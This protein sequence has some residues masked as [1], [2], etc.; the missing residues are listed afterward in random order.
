MAEHDGKV[1]FDLEIDDSRLRGDLSRIIGQVKG[2]GNAKVKVEADTGTAVSSLQRVKSQADNI[3]STKPIV[4]VD[5]QTGTANTALDRTKT[6]ADDLEATDPTVTV[7]AQTGGAN[8]TLDRTKAKADDLESSDPT[9]TVTAQTGE[10]NGALEHTL[11]LA[12]D[13]EA[14]DPTVTI[15]A[16]TSEVDKALGKTG[17]GESGGGLGSVVSGAAAVGAA[18]NVFSAG[19]NYD[20]GLAQ[21]ATLMPENADREAFGRSMLA[22]ST[23]YGV[24]IETLLETAY[25]GL[26]ASV[27]YGNNAAGNNLAQFVE[28]ATKLS[29]AGYTTP[30]NAGDALSSVYNAYNGTI[31]YG[32]ISN[33]MLKTQNK[34][35]ITVD[36]IAQSVAQITP[37]ASTSG[38]GFDQVGAM[39][40]A[41][42]AGGV[43]P[44]QAATQ[45]RALI[46]ELNTGGSKGNE[47]MLAALKGTDYEGKSLSQIMGM[48]G[49]MV[50]VLAAIQRNASKEGKELTNY[51][52][53]S[54]AA[55][56]VA[57]L[58]GEN[59]GRFNESLQYMR[60]ETDVTGSA[61]S[62]M[63]DTQKN[64]WNRLMQ[65]ASKTAVDIAQKVSPLTHGLLQFGA[66]KLDNPLGLFEEPKAGT[67]LEE[68]VNEQNRRLMGYA[69][70]GAVPAGLNGAAPPP[71]T[72]RGK[73][74]GSG[75]FSVGES[76]YGARDD[77][78]GLRSVS[79]M[80]EALNKLGFFVGEVDGIFGD[81]TQAGVKAFQ[82]EKGLAETG[83]VDAETAAALTEA[84]TQLN[85]ETQ[86]G[87]EAATSAAESQ[88]QITE[89]QAAQAE[90]QSAAS[91][92]A[93]L[94]ASMWD[95]SARQA[96][97]MKGKVSKLKS[98]LSSGAIAAGGLA[99]AV[100]NLVSSV[101]S[102][103]SRVAGATV[104][105]PTAT[106]YA[107][108]LDYV[109]Y[110]NY[111]AL[112]HKGEMI[113]TA[114]QA[115]AF[116]VN[117]AGMDGGAMNAAAL[118]AAL[119]GMAFEIDGRR[120]GALVERGVSARQGVVLN[121]M[122]S[123]G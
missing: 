40:A 108:G 41:L 95:A 36:Q 22:L 17:Q 71:L 113:L 9:V 121:R 94:F 81:R 30:G 57:F 119:N 1:T 37:A 96:Q 47:S 80:Q 101:N 84:L 104:T 86:A 79:A 31:G 118:K 38:I 43:Q 64:Y 63:A 105:P 13:V 50:D 112:L 60:D 87:V 114:A 53:S 29:I 97:D 55:G 42:T 52:S 122:N 75:R 18:K 45:I 59:E 85:T 73:S 15:K 67:S 51:F 58:T 120:A 32:D 7:H 19:M 8:T 10:A 69:F 2:L 6:K 89:A 44:A 11:A 76:S 26:S 98:A 21:V 12:H 115:S 68:Y 102:A 3:A 14:S 111:P 5:A 54:E 33:L 82:K 72:S 23:K 70:N 35:K 62:T 106:K 16:D 49:N 92:S 34:G 48:G 25:N 65:S 83:E 99:G 61:Y 109:P 27:P 90:S 91:E 93:S 39:W 78:T 123:R 103:A 20:Y 4:T 116:R 28:N 117:S 77:E 88:A 66:E 107:V 110:D 46:N 74:K 56:A 100:T 24:P